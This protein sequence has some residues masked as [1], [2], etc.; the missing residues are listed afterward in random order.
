MQSN[1]VSDG[2]GEGKRDMRGLPSMRE[3]I[4]VLGADDEGF[5]Q[6]ASW[7]SELPDRRTGANN[8]PA[9]VRDCQTSLPDRNGGERNPTRLEIAGQSTLPAGGPRILRL[10]HLQQFRIHALFR[11]RARLVV[12]CLCRLL[13]FSFSFRRRR[14]CSCCARFYAGF[15]TLERGRASVGLRSR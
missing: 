1:T 6:F 12:R 9:L 14:R 2:N 7:E 3:R 10:V 4:V 11:P 15:V 8:P 13:S 5:I